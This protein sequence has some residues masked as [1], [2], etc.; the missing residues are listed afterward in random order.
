MSL[1]IRLEFCEENEEII[2]LKYFFLESCSNIY[3]LL[4]KRNKENFKRA[5]VREEN[6]WKIGNSRKCCVIRAAWRVVF[7]TIWWKGK[8][9]A[10]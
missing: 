7:L 1:R 2:L 4:Q 9:T 5:D 8:W 3:S 6:F 10:G